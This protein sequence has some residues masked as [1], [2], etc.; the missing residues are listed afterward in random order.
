MSSSRLWPRLRFGRKV[1]M[2][3]T[4]SGRLWHRCEQF[5]A[6]P[7]CA[8]LGPLGAASWPLSTWVVKAKA[9][10]RYQT[11]DRGL[12]SLLDRRLCTPFS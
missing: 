3:H 9:A 12:P 11:L 5:G 10:L 6:E 2:D 4:L 7:A 1:G 8:L